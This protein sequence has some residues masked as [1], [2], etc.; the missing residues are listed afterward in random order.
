MQKEIMVK[1][2]EEQ[3]KA[4]NSLRYLLEGVKDIEGVKKFDGKV[5]NKN[6]KELFR[7]YSV[8]KGAQ[9]VIF[10]LYPYKPSTYTLE[11]RVNVNRGVFYKYEVTDSVTVYNIEVVDGKRFSYDNFID[12]VDKNIKSLSNNIQQ[13]D[14]ELKDI[15]RI[16]LEYNTIKECIK[17]FNNTHSYYI[18]QGA[19]F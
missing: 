7:S 15:D 10:G 1:Y 8:D 18:T 19:K 2:L 5:I 6:L 13:L 14:N 12:A 3:L 17:N 4:F 16:I 11:L 9:Y